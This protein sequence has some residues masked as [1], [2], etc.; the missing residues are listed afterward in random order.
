MNATA[1]G[2]PTNAQLHGQSRTVLAGVVG[3]ATVELALA[4][5]MAAAPHAFYT[6]I[7]PFGA[8]N[9]HFVR[10][11]ATYNAALGVGLVIA[12]RRL[13]WRAP[14]LAI[15]TVQFA[16]H[17]I[18]HLIDIS[19]AHPAWIGYFDFFALAAATVQ[20]AGLTWLA[21]ERAPISPTSR[22]GGP[23]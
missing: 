4:G 6:A 16:L 23:R 17:S 13:S 3:F 18:N 14:L 7:G 8:R 1:V 21:M 11:V 20:L 5:F 9:D 19:S 22:K 15:L 2:R 10:D 12:I